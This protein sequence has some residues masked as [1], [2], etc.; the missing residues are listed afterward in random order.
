MCL[1]LYCAVLRA[2]GALVGATLAFM[3]LPMAALA[4]PMTLADNDAVRSC[5]VVL[6][7]TLEFAFVVTCFERVHSPA[8]C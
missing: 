2:V 4:M 1:C 3:Q 6:K 5:N 8:A 7:R